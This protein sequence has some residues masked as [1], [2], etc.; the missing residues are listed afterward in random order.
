[1][2]YCRHSISNEHEPWIG[3]QRALLLV[4]LRQMNERTETSITFVGTLTSSN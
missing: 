4:K 1:M 3:E 2:R